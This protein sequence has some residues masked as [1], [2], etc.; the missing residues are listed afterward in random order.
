MNDNKPTRNPTIDVLD[1]DNETLLYDTQSKTI[2]SLNATAYSIW[3][4]C[5]GQHTLSDIE[6]QLRKTFAIAESHD[7]SQDVRHTLDALNAK[8]LLQ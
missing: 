5:D 1:L 7:L 8:G 6:Q 3:K 4:M 2:H